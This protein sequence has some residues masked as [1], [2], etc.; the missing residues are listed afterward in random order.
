MRILML[1]LGIPAACC[2]RPWKTCRR[3]VPALARAGSMCTRDA[4]P[5]RESR[6]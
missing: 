1:S 5:P 4:Y 6:G 3:I 2:W